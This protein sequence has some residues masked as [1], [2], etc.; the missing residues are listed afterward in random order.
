M[1]KRFCS[2]PQSEKGF[3][4]IEVIVVFSVI[5]ILSSIGI[6]ASVNY[7]RAQ[8]LEAATQDLKTILNQAKSYAQSQYKPQECV[9]QVLE[10]YRI[11]L[12]RNNKEYTF[13]VIC[14]GTHQIT[15]AKLP[16]DVSFDIGSGDSEYFEYPILTGGIQSDGSSLSPW[17]IKL[18]GLG[19][20]SKIVTLDSSGSIK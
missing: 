13:S 4:L 19:G 9:N 6:S 15:K 7:S 20:R 16:K 12:D 1:I 3:T 2:N 5:A 18:L 8:S 17:Q 11:D 10:R 14:S